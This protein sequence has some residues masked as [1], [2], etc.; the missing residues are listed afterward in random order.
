MYSLRMLGPSADFLWELPDEYFL[1]AELRPPEF[2][3]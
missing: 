3:C 2:F 1:C